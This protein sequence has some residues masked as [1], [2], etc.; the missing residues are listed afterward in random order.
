MIT[1]KLNPIAD[2]PSHQTDFFKSISAHASSKEVYEILYGELSPPEE[3]KEKINFVDKASDDSVIE[4][5]MPDN[6]LVLG[7]DWDKYINYNIDNNKPIGELFI[8]RHMGLVSRP[9]N[10][11]FPGLEIKL[12]ATT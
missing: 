11:I 12:I 9:D 4:I 3:F 1:I 6:C 10:G 2:H 7:K 8:K 5:T